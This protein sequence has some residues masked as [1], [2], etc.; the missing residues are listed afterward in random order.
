MFPLTER[1]CRFVL[2]YLCIQIGFV[3]L[4]CTCVVE[5]E[6]IFFLLDCFHLQPSL[7]QAH[8]PA[9]IL[10]ATVT[11]QRLF[12]RTL[13]PFWFFVLNAITKW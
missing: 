12:F 10:G 4:A 8:L 3:F 2:A 6:I 5:M 11:Q 13:S 1:T 7:P 9:E